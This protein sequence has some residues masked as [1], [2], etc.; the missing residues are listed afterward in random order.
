[1]A[2]QMRVNDF[3]TRPGWAI[4]ATLNKAPAGQLL[5]VSRRLGL[6]LPDDLKLDG[7]LSGVV[8]YSSTTLLSGG[9]A[10]NDVIAR[11][12]N[13]PPLRVSAVTASISPDHVHFDP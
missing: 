12:P 2:L 8:G 7:T 3:L 4:L 10:L 11:F 13:S 6:A 1:V 5:P 9:F